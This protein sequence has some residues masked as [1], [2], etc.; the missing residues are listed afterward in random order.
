MPA[1]KVEAKDT[2]GAG[3]IFHGAFVYGLSKGFDIEKIVKYA[4]IAAG[5]SV[6]RIGARQSIPGLNEVEAEYL[7]NN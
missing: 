1:L 2:T 4:N 5:I 7:K 3:D 6:T